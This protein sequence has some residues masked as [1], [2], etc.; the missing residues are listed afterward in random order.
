MPTTAQTTD[1]PTTA[2]A[3]IAA[4]TFDLLEQAWNRGDGAAFGAEFTDDADFVDIRGTHHRGRVA[5]TVGHQ[6]IFDSIYLGS[7]V[8]YAVETTRPL[9]PGSIIAVVGARLDAPT[10]PMAGRHRSRLTAT[11]VEQDGR[12]AIATFHNTLVHGEH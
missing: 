4:A 1:R 2:P 8:R 6:A 5:I 11:F 7:T 10:G 9:Q 12:W 3:A